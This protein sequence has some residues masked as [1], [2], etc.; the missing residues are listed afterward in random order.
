[1]CAKNVRRV[2][3]DPMLEQ[4]LRG[5]GQRKHRGRSAEFREGKEVS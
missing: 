5:G 4:G 1:M 2:F 3:G